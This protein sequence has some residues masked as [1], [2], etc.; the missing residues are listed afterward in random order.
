VGRLGALLTEMADERLAEVGLTGREYL[1]LAILVDDGP[2]SQLEL[3][4][5]LGKAPA[6]VVASIDRLEDAGLVERTRDPDDRRRSRVK[7]TRKG[8]SALAR[9]DAI[10]DG[11]LADALPGLDEAERTTLARLLAKGVGG[12]T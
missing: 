10:A 9:S 1:T 6:L 8:A 7:V 3:A 5:L 12:A 11:I 2:G 4:Q